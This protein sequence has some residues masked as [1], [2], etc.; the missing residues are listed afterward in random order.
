MKKIFYLIFC[1]SF[2]MGYSQKET[3][4]SGGDASG[5]GG[6]VSYSIGQIAYE[7]RSGSNGNLNQGV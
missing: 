3:L 4:A 5:S 1:L 7:Y 6:T 2:F